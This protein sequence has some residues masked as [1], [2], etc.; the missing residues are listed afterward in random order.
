MSQIQHA[1]SLQSC[2]QPLEDLLNLSN[3]SDFSG[4]CHNCLS[5]DIKID[6]LTQKL[7]LL[8]DIVKTSDLIAKYNDSLLLNQSLNQQESTKGASVS[9]KVDATVQTMNPFQCNENYAIS[10]QLE[11]D[12]VT[13]S[14]Q[15]FMLTDD[16][17]NVEMPDSLFLVEN[18]TETEVEANKNTSNPWEFND[19]DL[20][21]TPANEPVSPHSKPCQSANPVWILSD[22]PFAKFSMELLTAELEFSHTFNNR[23]SVYFG[24]VPYQ[25]Q[26]ASHSP[27]KIQQDSYLSKLSSYI[28]VILPNFSHNSILLNYY[29]TGD[30]FIP[31]HSD[32]ETCIEEN[33]EIVTVSLGATRTLQITSSENGSIV[34][35]VQL[36]HGDVFVMSKSSQKD[37]LHEILP[38]PSCTEPRI[39][40]T[41]RLMK[42][43]RITQSSEFQCRPPPPAKNQSS[44]SAPL[45]PLVGNWNSTMETQSLP[46]TL[47]SK[48]TLFIS[49]SMFRFLDSD[50]LSS[51][52]ISATKLFYPGADA[53]VMLSKLKND[54]GSV[55]PPSDIYLMTGTNNV[56]S[57]YF[58]S[59]S[60]KEAEDDIR[61]LL[62]YVK[63]VFSSATIHVLNI[64]PRSSLG[65]NDVVAE[66]NMLIKK[67]CDSEAQLDFMDTHHLFNYRDGQRKPFYFVRPSSKIADN[68]HLNSNGVIRLAKFLKYWEHKHTSI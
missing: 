60:L 3:V 63:S 17:G 65:R 42:H 9:E 34:R 58:G 19:P 14:P 22:S 55:T 13:V 41:F 10:S 29:E 64:L 33:S 35:K 36:Q 52:T 15:S 46:K 24:D 61:K 21:S 37:F 11:Y 53:K 28:H 5:K 59:R 32:S 66:L 54:L 44:R 38:Q 48:N 49:S 23:K 40:I 18:D 67:L 26:G 50:K 31:P 1:D 51:P 62:S 4:N 16:L 7:A 47:P 12:C 68:C 56:N 30:D 27:N 8:E 6:F 45:N 39:S 43:P 25:Y 2:E 57:I 20:S